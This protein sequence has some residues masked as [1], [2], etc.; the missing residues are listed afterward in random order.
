MVSICLCNAFRSWWYLVLVEM[1]RSAKG[2]AW[3]LY[4]GA[5]TPSTQRLG[6]Y[7]FWMNFG[8]FV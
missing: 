3:Y 5:M 2:L 4:Y 8:W 6:P 7:G 1:T